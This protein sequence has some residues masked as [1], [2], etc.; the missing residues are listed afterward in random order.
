MSSAIRVATAV[1]ALAALA[2]ICTLVLTLA[3]GIRLWPPGERSGRYYLHWGLVAVYELSTLVVAGLD[4]DSWVVPRAL[5]L[6]VGVPL[7]AAGVAVFVAGGRELDAAETGGLAGDLR[8]EGAYARTRNPQYV[9]MVLGR[10]GFAALANSRPT[11]S[12][13][14]LQVVWVL[15]LPFAEEPWLEDR[16]GDAY[17]R[18]RERTPRFLG[19]R[20]LRS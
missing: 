9:G 6:G 4:W 18:Y 13:S 1:G 10:I 17:D 15:L 14:A 20:S 19:R 16:F 5:R 3:T 8:T 11:A 2:V 12:L 7:L